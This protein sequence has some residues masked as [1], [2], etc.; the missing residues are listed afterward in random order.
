MAYPELY[1][2]RHGQTVWNAEGRLQGALNSP[3]TE[4]GRAQALAQGRILA[5]L[6]LTGFQAICS[7]L[8]R[9]IETAGLAVAPIMERIRTDG[10]LREIE[11]GAWSGLQ[12]DTL[13]VGY[14]PTDPPGETLSLYDMAP[15]GEGLA[16]LEIR[17]RDFLDSLEGPAVLITH[18]ITSRMLRALCLGLVREELETLPGGQG[19]VFHV[20]DGVQRELRAEA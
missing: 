12:R 4:L 11:V 9:T 5:G 19:N 15:E 1:V 17:C 10:R 7:P 2:L 13:G 16:R 18:G 3:L 20:K 6:D 14:D 8:G